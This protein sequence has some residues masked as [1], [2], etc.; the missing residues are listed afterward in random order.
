MAIS[1]DAFT[2]NRGTQ[3]QIIKA[4]IENGNIYF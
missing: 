2:P 3:D 4:A 1:K